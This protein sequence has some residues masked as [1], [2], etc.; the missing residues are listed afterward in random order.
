MRALLDRQS[1]LYHAIYTQRTSCERINSTAQALG[2][3]RPKVRNGRSVA[4]L[5]TLTYLIRNVRALQNVN[6]IIIEDH[7][8]PGKVSHFPKK[9]AMLEGKVEQSGGK[10][11]C[12]PCHFEMKFAPG[13]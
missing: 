10:E 5:N 9:S 6:A 11:R 2:I 8:L 1:P 7:P 12:I 3:E 4:H 13:C